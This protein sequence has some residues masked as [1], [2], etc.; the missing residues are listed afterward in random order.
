MHFKI[1]KTLGTIRRTDMGTQSITCPFCNQKGTFSSLSDARFFDD[2]PSFDI[3]LA[4][5]AVIISPM[6]CP[7]EDCFGLVFVYYSRK[8]WKV[9]NTHPRQRPPISTENVPQRIADSFNEAVDCYSNNCFI[10]S[11]IMCRKTLEEICTDK[12]ATGGSLQ[13]RIENLDTKI[14][15]PEELMDGMDEL[16]VLGNNAAH[17]LKHFN[18]IGEKEAEIAIIFTQKIIEAIYQHELLLTKLRSFKK[19]TI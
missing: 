2:A 17:E 11:A 19:P 15:I 3:E 5:D 4:Y 10:A 1:P 18:N 16:R 8:E 9:I 7:N 14:K 13:K 12:S 6:V